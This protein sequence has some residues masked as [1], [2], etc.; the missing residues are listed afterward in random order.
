MPAEPSSSDRGP[1]AYEP[2]AHFVLG[3]IDG[4]GWTREPDPARGQPNA[5]GDPSTGRAWLDE[6]GYHVWFAHDCVNGRSVTMLPYPRWAAEWRRVMPSI[7][8]G[9]CGLHTHYGIEWVILRTPDDIAA[10]RADTAFMD[11]LRERV[12][13]DKPLLDRMAEDGD[14][15][16]ARRASSDVEG[17]QLVPCDLHHPTDTPGGDM[18]MTPEQAERARLIISRQAA[19]DYSDTGMNLAIEACN[20][21]REL[22]NEPEAEAGPE[23]AQIVGDLQTGEVYEEPMPPPVTPED[24]MGGT[25][26]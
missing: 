5:P 18:T 1:A 23:R 6:D 19:A 15:C 14:C 9:D 26:A 4:T 24:F 12:K 22:L 8:C 2:D 25:D 16:F 20:L 7:D 17:E 3:R 10:R 13:Q 21:L 11:R